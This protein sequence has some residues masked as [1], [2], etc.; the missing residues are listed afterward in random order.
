MKDL[1]QE[2][3]F[4]SLGLTDADKSVEI[5]KQANAQFLLFGQLQ[6]TGTVS[7]LALRLVAVED[8]TLKNGIELEC[9]DC[10]PDDY[11]QGLTFLLQD[12][13]DSD[14]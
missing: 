5:G 6:T 14:R 3:R 11:L 7:S 4:Q 9:R 12:W 13:V 8:G 2:A 10:T 1:L